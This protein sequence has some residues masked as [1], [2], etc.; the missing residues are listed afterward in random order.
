VFFILGSLSRTSVSF[1]DSVSSSI[2]I[3]SEARFSFLG[4]SKT[5][6]ETVLLIVAASA[7]TPKAICIISQLFNVKLCLQPY[8]SYTGFRMIRLTS[9]ETKKLKQLFARDEIYYITSKPPV[10]MLK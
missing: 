10:S 9:S 3:T 8:Y 6:S 5:K 2:I 4:F 1:N 7:A